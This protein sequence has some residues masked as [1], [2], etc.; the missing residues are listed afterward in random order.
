MP[1]HSSII[2]VLLRCEH[3]EFQQEQAAAARR[4][5]KREGVSVEVVFAGNS[6]FT[7]IQQVLSFV[8]RPPEL[9][10]GAIVVELVGATEGYRTAARAAVSAGVAWVEISGLAAS[11]PLL[12]YE[13]PER[14]VM[15]VT[16]QEEDIGRIHAAQCR[17][18]LPAGAAILYIEGPTLQP[19][20]KARRHGLEEGLRRTQITIGRTLAGDWT[21]ESAERAMAVFLDR[22]SAQHFVPALVCAQN[23]EMAVGARR[24]A[25][26]RHPDWAK[27]PYLGCD[28]IP[29]GGER[30]VKEGLLAA[31]VMKPVT[32]GVAVQ[33][34]ARGILRGARPRDIALAPE[35][36]PA[37]EM[38]AAGPR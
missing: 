1:S 2:A 10:P 28:G 15:A 9:R 19:E 24:T 26:E 33:H 11:I 13:F 35:S 16:T 18:I 5:G 38:I 22:P 31:T 6:P 36:L 30:Y 7:Q 29:R 21:D 27:L 37:L 34:A 25:V 20:V 32:A 4:A 8:E 3:Q 14:F 17:A 12:R 23:D